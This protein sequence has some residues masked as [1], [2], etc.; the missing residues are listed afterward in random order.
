M[1]VLI[2]PEL[3]SQ[4]SSEGGVPRLSRVEGGCGG[5][6]CGGSRLMVSLCISAE[7]VK[8]LGPHTDISGIDEEPSRRTIESVEATKHLP[9]VVKELRRGKVEQEGDGAQNPET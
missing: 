3:V 9:A 8:L 6:P 5:E 4:G 7:P 1:E 2:P